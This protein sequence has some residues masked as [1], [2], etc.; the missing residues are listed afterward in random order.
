MKIDLRSEDI[1]YISL[2]THDKQ[3]KCVYIAE[4]YIEAESENNEK[5]KKVKI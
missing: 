4:S 5:V 2:A 3:N 1:N